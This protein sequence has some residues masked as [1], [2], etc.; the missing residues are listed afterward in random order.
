MFPYVTDRIFHDTVFPIKE[1]I[2]LE[3]SSPRKS[4]K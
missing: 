1:R 4:I 2:W 3:Q